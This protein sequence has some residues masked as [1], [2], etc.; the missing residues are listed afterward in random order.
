[1]SEEK[2]Y[3]EDKVYSRKGYNFTFKADDELVKEILK[4]KKSGKV[5]DLA[6]GE[7]G[8]AL[9]LAQKGF[10]VTCLDISTTAITN[11]KKEIEKRGLAVVALVVDLERYEFIDD[12]DIII[13][14]GFFHF[15][16]K[17]YYLILI[18]NIMKHTKKD[19]LNI[20]EVFLE[21]DPTQEEDS[22]GYFFKKNELKDLYS[23]WNIME[24][25]EYEE[26]NMKE[27]QINKIAYL[28]AKK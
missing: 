11:V 3:F 25:E 24:Y 23:N 17:N 13:G 6:C 7:A 26:Y 4:H 1:M 12:Y 5:I 14:T 9:A 21:G 28:I 10:E 18:K 19:G 8:T 2:R 16:P 27:E 15:I 20:F 22:E